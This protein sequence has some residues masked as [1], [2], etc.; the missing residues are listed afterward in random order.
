MGYRIDYETVREK[1]PGRHPVAVLVA[2]ALLAVLLSAALKY[3]RAVFARILSP[4]DAAQT[5]A[6]LEGLL[7]QLR[8]GMPFAQA[9]QAFCQQV[10]AG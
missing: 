3:E 1:K 10:I 4:G 7:E 2:F 6:A 5:L 9:M 8:A